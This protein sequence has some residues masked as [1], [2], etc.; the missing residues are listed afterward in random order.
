M[1]ITF[2]LSIYSASRSISQART[3]T[4]GVNS[5]LQFSA[6]NVRHGKLYS[7]DLARR[8]SDRA[9]IVSQNNRV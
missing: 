6:E 7:S 9:F 4:G 1:L 8:A 5:K 3:L 2:H